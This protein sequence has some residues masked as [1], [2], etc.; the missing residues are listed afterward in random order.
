[1]GEI[2]E[3]NVTK[4]HPREVF[5]CFELRPKVIEVLDKWPIAML[6]TVKRISRIPAMTNAAKT[7]RRVHTAST[8]DQLVIHYAP[9]QAIEEGEEG[10]MF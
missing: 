7:R 1:M 10:L 5:L 2:L 6:L 3:S 8:V 4:C 9:E